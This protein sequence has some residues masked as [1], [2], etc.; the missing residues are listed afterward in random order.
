MNSFNNDLISIFQKYYPDLIIDGTEPELIIDM[1]AGIIQ[2]LESD[3]ESD[4]E[5][6]IFA[7]EDDIDLF[8][9][10]LLCDRINIKNS[11]D[12]ELNYLMAV[13][14][15][16][17]TIVSS[18]N[19]ILNGK[20]NANPIK[21]LFDCGAQSSIIFKSVV[22]KIGLTHL[23]DKSSKNYGLTINNITKNHGIIWYTEL[24]I[25]ID[26]DFITIPTSLNVF[27]DTD[28]IKKIN[29]LKLDFTDNFQID[30]ILGIDFMKMYKT[31][32]DF[33]KKTICL[34]NS[35]VINF[36]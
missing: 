35:I 6:D 1:L 25:S 31:T 9:D 21:I 14:H 28:T 3:K 2:K 36:Q 18:N 19:I 27:D 15:L 5:N 26:K 10:D 20:I 16:P 34:N 8:Q 29:E 23:I 4:T 11:K 12:L 13:E 30:V 22:D 32:I 7:K 33:N 24:D 17:E